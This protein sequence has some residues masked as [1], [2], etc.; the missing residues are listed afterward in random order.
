[1]RGFNP[2]PRE[3][4]DGR[5]VGLSRTA[6]AIS[7]QACRARRSSAARVSSCVAR[8]LPGTAAKAPR[9]TPTTAPRSTAP[10]TRQ[11]ASWT[12]SPVVGRVQVCR[13]PERRGQVR[14]EIFQGVDL[15]EVW[16]GL[17]G[18]RRAPVPLIPSPL[19]GEGGPGGPGEGS[20]RPF[21]QAFQPLIRRPA[22]ATFSRKG[23]RDRAPS[24]Q[25]SFRALC[26]E[27]LCPPQVRM[28]G[29]PA[30]Q[31]ASRAN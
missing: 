27:P 26:P 7:A 29:A 2:L 23:R 13:R 8:N 10:A 11:V 30:R 19:A 14:V 1:M 17:S 20:C 3:A 22:A 4:P 16:G 25:P 15:A 31:S 28:G 9:R 18:D 5:D 6:W 12:A 21:R 24:L